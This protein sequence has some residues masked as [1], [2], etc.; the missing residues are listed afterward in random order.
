VR[1]DE[2][3]NEVR[4]RAD[5][6]VQHQATAYYGIVTSYD[7]ATFSA[8]VRLQPSDI[9][10]GW[11]PIKTLL[12][13]NGFGVLAP[14]SIGDQVDIDFQEGSIE[15]GRVS[16]AVFSDEDRPPLVQSGE[17][18]ISNKAGATF[19][20]GTDG[21]ITVVAPGGVTITGDLTVTGNTSF[22]GGSKKVVLDGDPVSGGVVHASST[23][24]NAT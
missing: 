15:A 6:S 17:I 12:I 5:E 9:E 16:G 7:P 11:L 3:W 19:K 21:A 10:T 2:L 18:L 4:R 23:T 13:G 8:K 22:G 20:L 14:P 1:Q 24:I